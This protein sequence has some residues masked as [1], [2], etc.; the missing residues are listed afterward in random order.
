VHQ[1]TTSEAAAAFP[2][3]N[4]I[5][6]EQTVD[7]RVH[8]LGG[9]QLVA[10]LQALPAVSD[11]DV[12]CPTGSAVITSLHSTTHSS[13]PLEQNFEHIIHAVAPSHGAPNWTALL[14]SCYWSTLDLAWG[15]ASASAVSDN[16]SGGTAPQLFA[17]VL[18]LLGAGAKAVPI[19]AAASIAAESCASWRPRQP[20]LAVTDRAINTHCEKP[21]VQL[22]LLFGVQEDEVAGDVEDQFDRSPEW[23]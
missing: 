14:A 15:S 1:F 23:T 21:M 10:A 6:P 9:S 2:G 22:A 3:T 16:Q 17:V 18:P 13:S 12:R 11:C 4:V 5:Y 8:E 19:A 7:G 20:T